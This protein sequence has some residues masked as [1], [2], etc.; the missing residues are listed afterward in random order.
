MKK[1][2]PAIFA[3]LA[4]MM[5]GVAIADDDY[6][7]DRY[8]QRVQTKRVTKISVQKAK[9]TA[10]KAVGGGRVTSIDYDD[11]GRPHYDIDVVKKSVKYEVKIDARTGKVLRK[12]ID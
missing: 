7:D 6:D 3:T 12:K 10:I 4:L 11:D 8:E 2:F 1:L 9:N 5:S